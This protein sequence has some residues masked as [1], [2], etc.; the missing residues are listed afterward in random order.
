M[1]GRALGLGSGAPG[2]PLRPITACVGRSPQV[3]GVRPTH[4][5]TGLRDGGPAFP[6]WVRRGSQVAMEGPLPTRNPVAPHYP[7]YWVAFPTTQVAPQSQ[8]RFIFTGLPELPLL[9]GFHIEDC[10]HDMSEAMERTILETEPRV[11]L[12][13]E[14]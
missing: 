2:P 10:G 14:C 9:V 11:E 7:Q 1:A 3:L 13:I 8:S 5:A 6:G 4:A 12:I